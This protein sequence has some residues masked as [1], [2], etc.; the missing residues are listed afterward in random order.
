MLLSRFWYV[1]LSIVM[2]VGLYVVFLAVG[3]YDRRNAGRDERGARERQPGH[4]LAASDRFA[5]SPRRAPRRRGRQR[6]VQDARS[7][8]RERERPGPPLRRRTRPNARSPRSPRTSSPLT[9]KKDALFAVDRDGRVVR[10]VR[11]RHRDRE[12]MELGG[13]PA[14]FDALHGYLRDDTWVLGGKMYRVVARPV[15]FDV[16]Q[17]PAGAIV[18]MKAVDPAFAKD[19]A[20]RTRTNVA[21]YANNQRVASGDPKT[22]STRR[23]WDQRSPP[24][25]PSSRTTSRTTRQGTP[26]FPHPLRTPSARC[27]GRLY[28][29]AWELGTGYAVAR[30]RVDHRR[31]DGVHHRRGRQRTRPTSTG[32]LLGLALI[33]R[34][35]HRRRLH[36]PRAHRPGKRDHRRQAAL[37][38]ERG[39]R[40]SSSSRGCAGRF[41]RSR[42]T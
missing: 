4:R 16:T 22:A 24:S 27:T 17:A 3:Q 11:L 10:A 29:D 21:F 36:V 34:S 7:V 18:G 28:G 26:K 30:N 33:G 20:H 5:A 15:E 14:V 37:R 42:R 32:F 2:A 12:D 41:A 31:A 1:V 40:L 8:R 23:R 13:Y 38:C 35:P 6:G 39:D 19:L 25:S 9:T